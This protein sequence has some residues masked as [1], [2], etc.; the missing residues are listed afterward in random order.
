MCRVIEK[1]KFLLRYAVLGILVVILDVFSKDAVQR[2]LIDGSSIDLLPFLQLVLVYNR[3]AAFGFLG[4]ASGWQLPFFVAVGVIVSIMIVIRLVRAAATQKWFEAALVLIL[5]G[6]IGNLIDRI[7][8]GYVVD[9]IEL[10]YGAWRFPA[11]NVADMAIFLGAVMLVV[12][13]LGILPQ[14]KARG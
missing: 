5:A 13:L 1:R 2:S 11:F 9:F 10:Y 8:V 12:E 4:E 3:G 6:A 7:R 14:R